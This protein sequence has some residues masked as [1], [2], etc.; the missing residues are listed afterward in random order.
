MAYTVLLSGGEEFTPEHQ[1]L[2]KRLLRMCHSNT[3]RIVVIT[4]T[5]GDYQTPA[6]R[7]A[8]RI[9]G[10]LGAEVEFAAVGNP[11]QALFDQRPLTDVLED[12][13]AVYFSDGNPLSLV[14]A[15]REGDT[16]SRLAQAFRR[17]VIVAACG[18]GAMALCDHYWDGG[19]WEPGVGL[20]HGIAVLP[21][22]E[23][24]A[25]RFPPERLRRGLPETTVLLGLEDACG[26]EFDATQGRPLGAMP[27]TVYRAD[28]TT[29]YPDGE[30]FQV[31]QP[32]IAVER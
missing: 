6:I 1:P 17:G 18:A 20:L 24:V 12:A 15:L 26:V 29:V 11:N 28:G 8:K 10:Q 9:F 14:T 22:H 19:L 23:R 4:A 13:R 32:P 2:D 25:K 16:L 3:P 5:I 7:A 27:L 21:H 31:G 30:P